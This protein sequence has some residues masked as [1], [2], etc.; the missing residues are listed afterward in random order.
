MSV[1]LFYRAIS[2]KP[3]QLGSLNSKP[4]VRYYGSMICPDEAEGQLENIMSLP[5]VSGSEGIKT[6]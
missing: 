1:S 3:I 2:Q 6:D 5:I 4:F